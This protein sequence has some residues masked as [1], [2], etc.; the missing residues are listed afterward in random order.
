MA[1]KASASHQNSPK[2][3]GELLG[4]PGPDTFLFDRPN[5]QSYVSMYYKGTRIINRS[6]VKYYTSGPM[7]WSDLCL[8]QRNKKNRFPYLT[9]HLFLITPPP[10][11]PPQWAKRKSRCCDLQNLCPVRSPVHLYLIQLIPFIEHKRK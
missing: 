4:L 10:G 9:K 6:K 3:L 7:S 11:P 8:R 5:F 1:C 2:P